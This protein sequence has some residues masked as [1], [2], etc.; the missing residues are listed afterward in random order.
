[1]KSLKFIS[2]ILTIV[3]ILSSLPIISF[4]MGDGYAD[5]VNHLGDA[6]ASFLDGVG[7]EA[8]G[9]ALDYKYYSPVKDGDNTKYP[10]VIWLQGRGDNAEPGDQLEGSDIVAWATDEIQQRF[11]CSGGAFIFVPRAPKLFGWDNSLMD[12]L[13]ACIDDFI[14]KNK[15]NIDLTRIYLGGYSIGSWMSFKIAAVYPEM[16]A[17]IFVACPPWGMNNNTAKSIADIPV[18]IVSSKNDF[19]VNHYTTVTPIWKKIISRSNVP[20]NGRFSVLEKTAYPDGRI[21][22]DGH[23]SWHVLT[24]DGFSSQDSDYPLMSTIDGNG[25]AVTL[26][27]PNGVI[28]WL[29]SFTSDYNNSAS[30]DDTSSTSVFSVLSHIISKIVSYLK[31]IMR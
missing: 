28:S 4:G 3:I 5:I 18:W 30:D 6:E 22:P 15:D 19:F 17:A 9:Y 23:R 27:Y 1:M 24:Y 25:N 16:I 20:E 29:M 21:S 2:I 12:P 26:T 8:N 14:E 13:K 11:T 10:L 31:N 7:P